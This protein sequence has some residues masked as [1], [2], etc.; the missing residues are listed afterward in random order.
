MNTIQ[1]I[2]LGL[3]QGITEWLPISSEGQSVLFMM[4]YLQLDPQSALSVAIFLHIGTSLAVLLKFRSEFISMLNLRSNLFRIV[5]ISTLSTAI[6]GLPLYI[7]IKSSFNNGELATLLIGVLLIVTGIL[8]MSPK[9]KGYKDIDEVG[10]RDL[11]ILGLAQGF[12][13]LPGISRSGTTI[14]TL[15]LSGVNQKSAL[16]ISFL[17]S[18]PVVLGATFL[19]IL[20][21]S[22]MNIIGIEIAIV[23]V[24]TAF[25]VGYLMMDILLRFAERVNFSIFCITL[26]VITIIVSLPSFI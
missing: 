22:S 25:V 9:D 18:V 11:V 24:I 23:M 16:V 3:L 7:L 4:N 6:T 5:F 1:A 13:I 8:L 26:G 15:L 19:D 10:T 17:I 12:S 2:L 20:T 14:A 21:S